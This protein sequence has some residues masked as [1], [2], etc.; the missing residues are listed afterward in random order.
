MY[1]C[2]RTTFMPWNPV[3]ILAV[4]LR[5]TSLQPWCKVIR[6]TKACSP[7]S[8]FWQFEMC[9]N[10]GITLEVSSQTADMLRSEDPVLCFASAHWFSSKANLAGRHYS[11]PTHKSSNRLIDLPTAMLCLFCYFPCI[12]CNAS[13]YIFKS[14][15]NSLRKK[16]RCGVWEIEVY[17]PRNEYYK[18]ACVI[19]KEG[20]AF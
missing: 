16:Q 8:L 3:F 9:C 15:L 20:F 5:A 2:L 13:H 7:H 19:L 1:F 6:K 14:N 4:V 12:F 10:K 11:L 17:E 18:N